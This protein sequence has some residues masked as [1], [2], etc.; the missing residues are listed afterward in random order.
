MSSDALVILG[1]ILFALAIVVFAAGLLA[2][3]SGASRRARREEYIPPPPPG[4]SPSLP[5]E[6][7]SSDALGPSGGQIR[8]GSVEF[9][10]RPEVDEVDVDVSRGGGI[11]WGEEGL[12]PTGT[13]VAARRPHKPAGSAPEQEKCPICRHLFIE[14]GELAV[15]RCARPTCRTLIHQECLQVTVDC[16]ICHGNRFVAYQ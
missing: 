3:T 8:W 6:E 12:Q 15:V 9:M 7:W 4:P 2:F 14:T 1:I 13:E 5:R 16:P 10:G 11:V